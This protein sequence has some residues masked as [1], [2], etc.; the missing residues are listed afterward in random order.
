MTEQT[1]NVSDPDMG[2]GA[3]SIQLRG[4]G[5]VYGSG[6]DQVTALQDVTLDVPAGQITGV[7]GSSGAGKS[8]LIRMVNALERPTSGTVLV[9]G[10]DLS[11]LGGSQLRTFKKRTGMVFQ[12]FNLLDSLT[13]RANVELPLALDGVSAAERARR[14]GEAL[15]F[16]GLTEKANQH[17]AELSGGQKQRV[18]IA[19]AIIRQ[20]DVLLCDE[21]TS[22]LDPATTRQVVELLE[23]INRE[24]GVTI[25]VVTH[26][27]DV[28]KDLCQG[29]SVMDRGRIVET[30]SVLDVFLH[31]SSEIA[32]SFVA[33][34][35]PAHPVTAS[36]GPG[37]AVWRVLI[38]D[39]QVT[40]PLLS[41]L[42]RTY[43]LDA[44]IMSANMTTIQGHTVG[45]LVVELTGPDEVL[46]Q[47]HDTL[48]AGG[49][50]VAEVR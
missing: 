32:R 12:H 2:P 8:T 43:D 5:K 49:V 18:G 20:P 10:A 27:M 48:V 21:A 6:T 40:T 31:P 38:L 33:D 19:R 3:A 34:I 9:G 24:T 35:L 30:G 4:V 47:A 22:A 25:L 13:V 11:R 28:I 37:V 36:S 41:T 1:A 45:E 15:E 44:N 7:I 16:V 29:V 14:A 23:R 50:T 17:P 26:E 42:I 39:S 46:Q